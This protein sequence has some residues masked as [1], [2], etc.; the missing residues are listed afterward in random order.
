MLP[1]ISIK[2]CLPCEL[3]LMSPIGEGQ[4]FLSEESKEG[5]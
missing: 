5:G 4:G 2:N 1:P 3:E